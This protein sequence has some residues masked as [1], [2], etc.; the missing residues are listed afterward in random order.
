MVMLIFLSDVDLPFCLKLTPS[1]P[2]DVSSLF[3]NLFNTYSEVF[4]WNI[5]ID[6]ALAS[7]DYRW[8]VLNSG[9]IREKIM[10]SWY[11]NQEDRG[12]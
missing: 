12:G 1:L 4:M 5:F 3:I 10:H 9:L 8:T 11:Y 2:L 7:G 6:T